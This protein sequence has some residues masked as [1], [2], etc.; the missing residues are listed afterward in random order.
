MRQ[1]SNRRYTIRGLSRLTAALLLLVP[2]SSLGQRTDIADKTVSVLSGIST[3]DVQR[4][5]QIQLL[6]DAAT[7]L[8]VQVGR[9]LLIKSPEPIKRISITDP[10][11]A[12]AASI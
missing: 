11:I 12:T 1:N 2:L 6:S 3:P 7:T 9:T 10:A 5:S 4:A 8:R